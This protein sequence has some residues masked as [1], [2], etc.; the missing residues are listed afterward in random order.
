MSESFAEL[1]EESIASQAIK[2]GTII[3]ASVVH[4]GPDVVIVNAVHI[5]RGKPS[6]S[7]TMLE[8]SDDLP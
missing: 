6:F 8:L 1:F 3:M 2:P 5:K 4:I 7:E